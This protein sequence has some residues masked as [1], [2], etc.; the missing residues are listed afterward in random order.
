MTVSIAVPR[1]GWRHDRRLLRLGHGIRAHP[2]IVTALLCA[3]VLAIGQ[4]G[5]DLPAQAYRVFLIRH[6]GLVAFDSHWYAGHALP[7][8][9]LLFPPLAA[10]VGA[11]LVGALSCIAATA[12]FTRLL[13]GSQRSGHDLAVLWFAVVSVVD[14]VVGR[15][16]FALGLAAGIGSVVAARD[17]RR[18]WALVL[19]LACGCASPLSGAFLL[20]AAAVWLPSAGWRTVLPLGAGAVGIGTAALFGEGGWFPFPA[21]TLLVILLLSVGGLVIVPRS[22]TLVRRGLLLY[23][24][25]SIA[26]FPFQNPIGGNMVRLGAVFSGP[27]IAF[28]LWR[29]GRRRVLAVVAIPLLIWQFAPLPNALSAGR[30][31]PSSEAGYY[32]G[33]LSYLSAHGAE[34]S[35]L[36]VPLTTGRWESDYLA[37]G[38]SLARGWE[39][40]LD[41]GRNSVLYDKTL[42]AEA[43]HQWLLDTGVRWVALPD[44]SLDASEDGEQALLTGP[45]PS[46]LRPV[47]HDQHWKLWEVRDARPL[48]SGPAELV[49]LGVSS[50]DLR[51][52]GAGTAVVLVRWTRFW[53]VTEGNA[54]VAPTDD[55]WTQVILSEPGPVTLTAKVGLGSLAGAG[56]DG[57]CSDD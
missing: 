15:L 18:G 51:A 43:Y 5:P 17:H 48:V 39:R 19:A 35:R 14:L 12:A 37:T 38:I 52:T 11:R 32:T 7:G 8:Y 28:E 57:S 36:E 23:G 41:L 2:E 22:S 34:T 3:V 40:Q 50:I 16:P 20:L 27:L 10:V 45:T 13:R 24:V 6:H 30:D 46:Y 42:T 33:L 31:N 54:C 47:W 49:R 25:A 21:T 55:N 1:L 4:R 56:G 29:S 26:L 53:R 9:S 44:V